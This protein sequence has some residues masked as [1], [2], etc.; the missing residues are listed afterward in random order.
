M[1]KGDYKKLADI[2]KLTLFI[3][4]RP[5]LAKP[6]RGIGDILNR[7]EGKKLTC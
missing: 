1:L 2:C 3:P 6:T 5:M 4:C 7:F